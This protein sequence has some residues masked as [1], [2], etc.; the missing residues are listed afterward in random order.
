AGVAAGILLMGACTPEQVQASMDYCKTQPNYDQCLG[1]LAML[2][3]STGLSMDSNQKIAHIN[4]TLSPSDA[5]LSRLREC[6]ASGQY[7]IT[8]KSGK[9]MG[10]YQFDQRTWNGAAKG[11]GLVELI[12]V[13]PHHASPQAQ[14]AMARVLYE[15][16]GR[17]PWPECGKR[18]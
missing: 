4:N 16:R 13:K 12:N 18:I 6:E 10:A 5:S 1:E 17:S 3:D 14:D 7:N 9:Y 11:N 8:N 15:D 2:G